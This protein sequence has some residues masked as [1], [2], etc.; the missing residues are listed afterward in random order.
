MRQRWG[1]RRRFFGNCDDGP[2]AGRERAARP[3]PFF[4]GEVYFTRVRPC[5]RRPPPS[6]AA[7]RGT[8]RAGSSASDGGGGDGF[9]YEKDHDHYGDEEDEDDEEEEGL[10][11]PTMRGVHHPKFFLLFERSGS[12]VIIVSTSNLTPQTAMEGSWVQRFESID[13]APRPTFANDVGRGGDDKRWTDHGMPSDFGAVLTD[14]LEKQSDAVGPGGG[15]SP[16][17]SSVVSFPVYLR[18]DWPRCADD[19]ASTA[20]KL[21]WCPRSRATTSAASRPRRGIRVGV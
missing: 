13:T 10:E 21:T 4:G 12:L 9:K 16:T 2:A 19:I 18:G 1:V 15:C 7:G 20:H 11:N 8:T 6:P 3:T 5:R 17:S 14:F